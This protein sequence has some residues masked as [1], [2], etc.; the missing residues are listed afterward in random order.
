MFFQE[1]RRRKQLGGS[2]KSKEDLNVSSLETQVKTFSKKITCFYKH[3][4][5]EAGGFSNTAF[6]IY[7]L[8]CYF[9]LPS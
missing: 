8:D 9:R 5:L 4:I 7:G 2:A 3:I 6:V 1:I